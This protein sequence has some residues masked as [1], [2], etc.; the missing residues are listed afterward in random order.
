MRN[1]IFLAS[2]LG[3]VNLF[4]CGDDAAEKPLSD[5]TSVN[6]SQ[7]LN[8]GQVSREITK[9]N[10]AILRVLTYNIK[11][12]PCL[13][14]GTAKTLLATVGVKKC[15]LTDDNYQRSNDARFAAIVEKLK[16]LVKSGNGP[17]VVL[18][19]EA[20]YSKNSM[21]T[22]QGV[23]SLPEKI[24][25]PYFAWGPEGTVDNGFDDYTNLVK[26]DQRKLKGLLSS[27][28]LV[29]SRYPILGKE[30]ILFGNDCAVED[31]ISNKGAM[32]VRISAPSI[33]TVD[34]LNTHVQ[35]E[36]PQAEIRKAQFTKL[37]PWVKE[38]AGA[39]F[40]FLG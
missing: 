26:Q 1:L 13:D 10:P 16:D 19:Q 20:F 24:G 23:R 4:G 8:P 28:L 15:P 25:Y 14:P 9:G 37:A 18:I 40:V 29:L 6:G 33:G 21:F 12:I 22:N 36:A 30:M 11:G 17:D 7:G 35:A 34:I 3:L 32:L 38:K 39:A 27:G 5:S 2:F 31:C